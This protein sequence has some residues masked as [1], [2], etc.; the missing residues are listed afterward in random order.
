MARSSS[1]QR[2][3]KQSMDILT[4]A[5]LVVMMR[6]QQ[7]AMTHPGNAVENSLE[8]QRMWMEKFAATQQAS[9]A[10]MSG[11]WGTNPWAQAS[12]MLAPVHA[13]VMANRKRLARG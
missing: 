11:M 2:V 9:V 4:Q 12:S 8:M 6:M 7:M 10:M 3:A 13:K 5:P 1:K